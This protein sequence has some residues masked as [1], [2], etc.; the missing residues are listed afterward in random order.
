[1]KYFK[2]KN[3]DICILE[4][5]I[6]DV[7]KTTYYFISTYTTSTKDKPST[8]YYLKGTVAEMAYKDDLETIKNTGYQAL[9]VFIN[10]NIYNLYKTDPALAKKFMIE[11]EYIRVDIETKPAKRK[12]TKHTKQDDKENS[13][14]TC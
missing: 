14:E 1:M 9:N 6:K 3:N 7:D 13:T 4:Y 8:T 5:G 12:Y 2:Y 10:S 11:A